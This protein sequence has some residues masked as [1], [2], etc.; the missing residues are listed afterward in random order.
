MRRLLMSFV[1]VALGVTASAGPAQAVVVDI[2]PQGHYGVALRP[3]TRS[4]LTTAGISAVTASAPCSDPWLASDFVLPDTGLCYHGGPVMHANETFAMTWDPHRLDWQTTRDYVEQ[5]LKDVGD[6]SGTLTSPYALTGQYSDAGGRARNASAYGGGCIDFGNPGGSTCRFP[7][8]V[9]TGAGHNDAGSDCPVTGTNSLWQDPSGIWLPHANDFCISDAQIRAEV[10]QMVSDMGLIGRT[11]PGYT[12]L[13]VLRTPPG[14]VDCIDTAGKLCS[15]N[16]AATAQFCSYHAQV[17]VGGTAVS[18]VVQPWT[19]LTACD[20]PGLPAWNSDVDVHTAAVEAGER[21]VSPISQGHM[22]AITDPGLD[23]WY[24]LDGSE[25]NDNGCLPF[26]KAMDQVTVGKSAQNPYW[27]QREFNNAGAIASDPNGP[28]CAPNVLLGPTFVVPSPINAGDIVAFD[29]SVTASTLLISQPDYVW[30]FG[31]GTSAQGASVIHSYA[32]GGVYS[33]KLTVTDRGG[34]A[35]TTTQSITVLGSGGQQPND[36]NNPNNPKKPPH[37]FQVRMQ[38]VPQG[39]KSVLRSGVAVRVSSSEPADGISTVTITRATA[40][41]AH[42]RAG[43]SAD[44]RIGHGTVAGIKNGTMSLRLRLDRSTTA[45][46]AR[47]HHLKLTVALALVG[48]SGDRATIR[49]AGSY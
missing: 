43:R 15:A 31:D 23:A 37:Q 24:A 20:D 3:G 25:M 34:N 11:Q 26:P 45:K 38:L 27:L 14:V 5:F 10:A 30:S 39:L 44:V 13:V 9:V 35:S 33:V 29:G 47:L 6:G 48:P 8:S 22:A 19:V 40:R 42:I 18:Y 17:S 49:A 12:P 2:G 21:L 7:T 41:R 32:R 36:P 16:S 28:K 4:T 1:L 46:L